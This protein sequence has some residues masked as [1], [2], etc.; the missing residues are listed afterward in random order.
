MTEWY[1][2]RGRRLRGE[3]AGSGVFFWRSVAGGEVVG[4]G[5]AAFVEGRRVR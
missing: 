1:D 5:R 4:R 2:V 3:P